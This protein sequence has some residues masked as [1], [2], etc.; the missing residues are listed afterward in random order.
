MPKP[1]NISASRGAAILGLS[2]W[3]TPVNIWL[4]IM[5]SRY[6]GFCQENNYEYPEFEETA[7][8]RWGKA[9]EDAIVELAELKQNMK[10]I[11][12]EKLYSNDYVNLVNGV[13][14]LD[15]M[16]TCHVD[17]WYD[18]YSEPLH[19]GKTTSVFYYR[20]NFGEPG[21]DQVP[22]EY[23]I[24]GQH[25]M[26][27]TGAEKVILS[28]LV[29]PRRVDEWEE[30]G[31]EVIN[32]EDY[33]YMMELNKNNNPHHME[34]WAR[35]LD[36]MGYFHQYE[37]KKHDE[38]QKLMISHYSEWW[39]KHVINK[40][41]PEPKSYDDIK[42][43]VTEPIGTIVADEKIERWIGEYKDIGK[44]ISDGGPLAK[45][46][47]QIK[48]DILKFMME[49]GYVEDDDSKDKWILRDRSG[50]KLIS[51]GKNKKG[52]WIFR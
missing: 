37:I 21:T 43:L 2:K 20:D 27:C 11:D 8:I 18:Y 16:V 30:M 9:F 42:L 49:S 4:Q 1:I 3:S 40:I 32:D 48:V 50:K 14:K 28:V 51:Y 46:R 5:E 36:Q 31:W 52:F 23:Q 26:I 17:G 38:L 22:I 34:Y 29:F 33:G 10:I 7:Q 6:P 15:P 47:E 13:S 39:E 19:E 41:P 25:Q 45:R 44:E 24:Q 35:I 12:R